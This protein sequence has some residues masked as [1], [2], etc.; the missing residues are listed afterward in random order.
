MF[1][2]IQHVH[3]VGIGGIGMCGLAELL[4][5]QG[6]RVS[7][8]DLREGAT[9]AR[10]RA[11]GVPVVVG[12]AS[13]NVGQADVVVYSSAVRPSNAELLEAERRKIPVIPRAEMLAEIMRLKH[14]IA[15]AG[16]H[17]KTTT[18]SLIAHVL[19]A[20]GFDPTAVIGGRVLAAGLDPTG[21]RLGRGEFLV[22]EADESDGSFLRLAPVV[23]VITNIDPEHLDH[24]QSYEEIQRAFVSFGNSVPFWGLTVL[25]L[26]HPGVQAILPR[27]TRRITTYGFASQADLVATEV[28]TEGWG[29]SF[30]VRSRGEELGGVRLRIPGRH[31]VSNALATLAVALELDVPFATAAGALENFLGIERRFQPR[32]EARGVRVV[33]D[34][35]H[36]PAEIRATLAA[37]RGLHRGRIVVVFQPHRYTRTRDLFDDFATAFNDADLVVLTEIYPAGED[38]LPGVEASLLVEAIRAHGHRDVRFAADLEALPTRLGPELCPGDLVVTLGAGSISAVGPRILAA[39][40]ERPA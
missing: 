25:C 24:Y 22:A 2:R 9:V 10:L 15:V 8:S 34:Y 21:A 1:R 33:D 31:N 4:H 26:D 17:G 11:L 39:L 30:R 5:N 13:D 14:G 37:A 27:M 20:A 6:Y 28:A 29:M 32:G 36:H 23:A 7:G 18:T 19:H 12:H 40:E 38:K 3:F 16:S 35:G